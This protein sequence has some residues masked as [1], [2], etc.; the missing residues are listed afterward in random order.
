MVYLISLAHKLILAD[1]KDLKV[2]TTRVKLRMMYYSVMTQANLE[3]EI[4]SAPITYSCGIF[5][6]PCKA[7]DTVDHK[8][9]LKDPSHPLCFAHLEDDMRHFRCHRNSSFLQ[10][11]F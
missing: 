2:F 1:D 9:L 8:I 10:C 6:D 4:L 5:L 11:K 7:F 3:K